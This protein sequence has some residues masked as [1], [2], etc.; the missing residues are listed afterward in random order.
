M[1]DAQTETLIAKDQEK[2]T[3]LDTTMTKPEP[4]NAG[5][6]ENAKI[7]LTMDMAKMLV[8]GVGLQDAKT[9]PAAGCK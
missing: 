4:L 3:N 7:R 9:E 8:K 5:A 2:D 6:A 1:E